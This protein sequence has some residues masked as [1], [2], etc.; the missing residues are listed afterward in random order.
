M[1]TE[2][3]DKSI[4]FQQKIYPG[5]QDNQHDP[6]LSMLELG[7]EIGSRIGYQK[8][9]QSNNT[10]VKNGVETHSQIGNIW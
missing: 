5:W 3:T 2:N 10:C 7:Q 8:G 6:E 1:L 9:D 4:G